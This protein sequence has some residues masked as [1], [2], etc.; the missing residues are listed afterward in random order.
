MFKKQVTSWRPQDSK[1]YSE[2]STKVNVTH[3]ISITHFSFC[4]TA[5]SL[6][7]SLFNLKA[8]TGPVA[9]LC[10]CHCLPRTAGKWVILFLPLN[11]FLEVKLIK[12]FTMKAKNLVLWRGKG[13]HLDLDWF[14]TFSIV[15]KTDMVEIST[16]TM[17]KW[18][19]LFNYQKTPYHQQLA[20]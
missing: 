16:E 19:E 4:E 8:I 12:I 15:F 3:K 18:K 9:L 1:N 2:M 13:R 14:F 5:M 7:L 20:S 11:S 6:F 10:T 17:R